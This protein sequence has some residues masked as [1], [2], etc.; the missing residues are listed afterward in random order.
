MSS[1]QSNPEP[2][3]GPEENEPG[4]NPTRPVAG[5][6]VGP[7]SAGV[8]QAPPAT[9]LP[10]GQQPTITVHPPYPTPEYPAHSESEIEFLKDAYEAVRQ[11]RVTDPQTIRT[12]AARFQEHL[13]DPN[14]DFYPLRAAEI[15]YS[16]ARFYEEQNNLKHRLPDVPI[17][18]RPTE[19]NTTD[20]SLNLSQTNKSVYRLARLIRLWRGCHVSL[21][22]RNILCNLHLLS[23]M[24]HPL[25]LS[26]LYP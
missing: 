10:V 5:V 4:P 9:N 8:Q 18:S 1:Q 15:L 13:Y 26:K 20:K 12:F 16:R 24:Y 7:G 2:I 11:G 19:K 25:S 14:L 23:Q 6:Q 21:Y 3:W 22:L 17:G